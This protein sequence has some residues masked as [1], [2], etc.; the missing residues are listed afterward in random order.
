M[1]SINSFI[2][3]KLYRRNVLRYIDEEINKK[4][5]KG[6]KDTLFS[7]EDIVIDMKNFSKYKPKPIDSEDE[8]EDRY[9]DDFEVDQLHRYEQNVVGI[10]KFISSNTNCETFSHFNFKSNIYNFDT[11]MGKHSS[12]G[13]L[14]S[15]SILL[16]INEDKLVDYHYLSHSVGPYTEK[17]H[18]LI[19][20]K[21]LLFNMTED[22][23]DGLMSQE[24][25]SDYSDCSD[26]GDFSNSN[27]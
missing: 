23:F 14:Y 21:K 24:C 8:Y 16:L 9:S 26:N 6:K 2:I 19:Y 13:W 15:I 25:C 11:T 7:D 22:E 27:E 18:I 1:A 3:D 17:K 10:L 5:K 4:I 20:G 12:D